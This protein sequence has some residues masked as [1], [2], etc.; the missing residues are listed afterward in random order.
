MAV[1]K[2]HGIRRFIDRSVGFLKK[3]KVHQVIATETED[4]KSRVVE[5]HKRRRRYEVSHGVFFSE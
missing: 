4:I 3:A 2:L 1:T 5:V